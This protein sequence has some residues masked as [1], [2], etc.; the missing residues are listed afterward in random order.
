MKQAINEILLQSEIEQALELKPTE[1][2][3]CRI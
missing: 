1:T 3:E 2:Y